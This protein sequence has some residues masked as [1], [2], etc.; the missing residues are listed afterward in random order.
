MPEADDGAKTIERWY[1]IGPS[2]TYRRAGIG[3][4][5][6][7]RPQF[8]F[9]EHGIGVIRKVFQNSAVCIILHHV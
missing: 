4:Q 8:A 6:T 1:G 5:E 9:T 2:I 7:I 3:S